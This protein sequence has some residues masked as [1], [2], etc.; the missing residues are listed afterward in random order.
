MN[1][2]FVNGHNNSNLEVQCYLQSGTFSE[3]LIAKRQS[4]M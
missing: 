3:N 4:L 1:G 2:L